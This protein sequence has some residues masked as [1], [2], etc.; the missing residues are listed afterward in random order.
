MMRTRT[1]QQLSLGLGVLSSDGSTVLLLANDYKQATPFYKTQ[2]SDN[3]EHQNGIALVVR[4][5]QI[6]E[7][8]QWYEQC[9]GKIAVLRY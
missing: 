7:Y 1:F 8:F 5:Y 9:K 2:H 3:G 6:R 4:S